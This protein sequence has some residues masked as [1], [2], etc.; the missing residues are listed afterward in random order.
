MIWALVSGKSYG[1]ALGLP[2]FCW[3]NH[4]IITALFITAKDK[5]I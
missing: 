4:P 1:G 2:A 5:K 3:N